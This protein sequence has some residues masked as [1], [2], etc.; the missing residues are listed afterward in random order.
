MQKHWMGFIVLNLRS[1]PWPLSSELGKD[2]TVKARFW[3]WLSGSKFLKLFKVSPVRSEAD[4]EDT[5][6]LDRLHDPELEK[7]PVVAVER[8]WHR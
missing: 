8:I 4:L 6:A 1:A 5:D 2:T 7:L 3:P